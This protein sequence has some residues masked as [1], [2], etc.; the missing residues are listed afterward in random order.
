VANNAAA[1]PLTPETKEEN[2]E[3]SRVTTVVPLARVRFPLLLKTI[4]PRP[5]RL[6]GSHRANLSQYNHAGFMAQRRNRY[7][8]LRFGL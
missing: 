1:T 8:R 4:L 5:P 6:R 2:S 3:L 7:R